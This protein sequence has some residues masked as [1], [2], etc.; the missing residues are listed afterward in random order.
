MNG[1]WSRSLP[2]ASPL[3]ARFTYDDMNIVNDLQRLELLMPEWTESKMGGSLLDVL[4][5]VEHYRDDMPQ[6]EMA[7]QVLYAALTHAWQ[8]HNY[9]VVIQLV[10]AMA[11]PAGRICSLA[12][13]EHLLRMGIEASRYQ[14]DQQQYTYFLN[15]LGG[16]LF[17]HAHYWQGRQLWSASLQ[18][19]AS[20]TTTFGLWEPLYSFAHIVD[21][22]GN[23]THAQQFVETL[24]HAHHDDQPAIMAAAL[25][26]RGFYER[27]QHELDHAHADFTRCLQLITSTE[28][29]NSPQQRLF[30]IIVQGELAR[31]E[32]DY[33][34]AQS[35]TQTALSLA[36]VYSDHYTLSALLFDQG[37]YAYSQSHFAD[38]SPIFVQ[39]REI[40]RQM[41]V[42]HVH[43]YCYFLGQYHLEPA[44]EKA[45]T[46][47]TLLL[48]PHEPLSERERTVLQCAA[49]GY[50]NREIA[51]MLVITVGTVKKHLEHIFIK[52]DVH[53][54]TAAIAKARATNIL[55]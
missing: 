23:Y 3:I 51:E 17:T 16:L 1:I 52:L 21:I 33:I 2:L 15:R 32:G 29:C 42:P 39:L 40:A 8:H 37:L 46:L 6:M 7:W 28:L 38:I 43:Q 19:S 44:H 55:L 48:A 14:Q 12:E 13:A 5:F 26:A 49:N 20:S 41:H 25:F 30:T 35:C 18:L 50:T 31:V 34:R 27:H 10:A 36:K 53:N 11:W 24:A 45:P 22:L 4:A 47:P 9:A 54:R